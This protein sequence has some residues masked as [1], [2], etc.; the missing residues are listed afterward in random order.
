MGIISLAPWFLDPGTLINQDDSW[1][2]T[3]GFCW[4]CLPG[5]QPLENTTKFRFESPKFFQVF[6]RIFQVLNDF[7]PCMM[8]NCTSRN[9]ISYVF[10]VNPFWKKKMPSQPTVF[11][12]VQVPFFKQPFLGLKQMMEFKMH[13]PRI[14]GYDG[15]MIFIVLGQR[16]KR[17]LQY[18][19]EHLGYWTI[20]KF[21]TGEVG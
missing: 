2:V 21:T 9:T 16:W 10:A 13:V 5:L 1:N 6:G 17:F 12:Y 4:R 3:G 14:V 7:R 19:P 11:C 20:I 15:L 18:W 8:W